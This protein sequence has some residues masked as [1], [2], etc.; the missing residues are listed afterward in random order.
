M[1]GNDC[2]VIKYVTSEEF[3]GVRGPSA[4]AIGQSSLCPSVQS[5]TS[6]ASLTPCPACLATRIPIGE[7]IKRK[8]RHYIAIPPGYAFNW[9]L[10]WKQVSCKLCWLVNEPL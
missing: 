2:N 6:L 8:A 7:K 3:L 9:N 4:S 10:L 5:R 1:S